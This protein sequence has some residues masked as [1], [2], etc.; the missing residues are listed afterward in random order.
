[1]SDQDQPKDTK[2]EPLKV[3]TPVFDIIEKSAD[4]N[5]ETRDIEPDETK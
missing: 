2:P 4:E 3:D 5:V 1:M